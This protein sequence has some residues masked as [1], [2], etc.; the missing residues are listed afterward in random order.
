VEVTE[1]SELDMYDIFRAAKGDARIPA[2]A[3]E[4]AKELG[5]GNAYPDLL[6]GLAQFEISLLDYMQ[7]NLGASE[8]GVFANKCWPSFEKYFGFVPCYINSR[9]AA[10]GIPISCESDIYGV[11]SEYVATC[12]TELPAA[13]LDINNTVP[14]D[15]YGEA[16]ASVGDYANSD[17][18]MGFHC[19]N[20]SSGCML[21]SA[22]K[23]QLI[24]H[25]LMEPGKEPNIT[26][27]TL[28]GQIMPGDVTIFRLQSTASAQLRAYVAQGEVLNVDPRSFGAI[29]IFAIREMG[30]FYRHVLIE[31]RFPHHTGVAFAHVGKVM[32]EAMRL[33][34][35]D[36]VSFNLPQGHLYPTEYLY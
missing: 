18:F 8:Y 32:H 2:V 4:M 20:T 28:E 11:L 17:L 12:A 21:H 19:G 25:R 9:F 33:V 24:M 22:M 34:G 14:A 30:R 13:I 3:Q 10:K 7:K 16:K 29:G 1:N 15:M 6:H 23:Y 27:G 26:R 5:R 35:I 31:K 36:D